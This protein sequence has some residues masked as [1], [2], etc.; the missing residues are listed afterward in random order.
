[1]VVVEE[2]EDDSVLTLTDQLF[3]LV[4]TFDRFLQLLEN[5]AIALDRQDFSDVKG[6]PHINESTNT[7]RS[8][9]QQFIDAY[10]FE[11]DYWPR[12]S[13]VRTKHISVQLV[14][15][16]IMGV[17]KGSE[18]SRES[19]IPLN[20]EDYLKRSS[21]LAPTFSSE[22]ERSRVYDIFEQYETMKHQRGDFDYVDR[23]VTLLKGMYRDQAL[24]QLLRSTFDEMYVDEVQDLR[25]LDIEL[26]F[27]I[28]RDGRG[29]H[30]AGD[31]AQAI[32]QDSTFRFADIKK[33]HYDHFALASSSTNQ[34][35]LGHAQLFA[36][37]ENHRSHQAILALASLV[38]GMI[39]EGFPETVDRLGPEIGNL[40]G[41]KPV[42]FIGCNFSIL[43]SSS[44]GSGNRPEKVA[45]FGAEQVILVR[46]EKMKTELRGLIGDVALIFT[47]LESKGMEFDDVILWDFFSGCPNQPGVRSLS[48]LK[49]EPAKF[50]SWKFSD[51]CT[52]LKRLYVA[53]TRARNQLF[54]VE[55]SVDTAATVFKLFNS[56]ASGALTDI[57][58]PGQKNFALLVDSMRPSASVDPASWA[59]RANDLMEQ[60]M[61]KDALMSFRKA[62]DQRGETRAQGH[63][64][65]EEGRRCLA[66]D[67]FEGS[68]TKFENA[69][70]QIREVKLVIDAVRVLERMGKFYRAAEL[71]LDYDKP[72][73]A[74]GLFLKAGSYSKAVDCFE[75]A[76]QYSE[77]AS[78][79]QDQGQYDRLVMYL[80]EHRAKLPIKDLKSYGFLCKLLLKQE[81]L[82][83]HA[84]QY[85]IELLG[86]SAEQ[87]ACFVQ[88]GMDKELVKLY[89]D[90]RR[91]GD[92]YHFYTKSGRLGS[93]TGVA[94]TDDLLHSTSEVSEFELLNLL[95]YVWAGHLVNRSSDLFTRDLRLES[96][97][98]NLTPK[99][100]QK[101]KQWETS[102]LLYGSNNPQAQV[103]FVKMDNT[104]VKRFLAFWIISNDEG[105]A[106]ISTLDALP[107]EMMQEAVRVSKDLV[108]KEDP[109][110]CSA[111]ALITGLWKTQHT[112][113]EDMF[114]P[115]SP[116]P[117][118][119][120]G[121]K[122]SDRPGVARQWVLDKIAAAV[123]ALHLRARDL[124][125]VKW[126]TRCV[127]FLTRGIPLILC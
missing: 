73:K 89:N 14:F 37:S 5:T 9:Q 115:W 65:E 106:R 119:M 114:L 78:I 58:R 70:A 123:Q 4:C 108:L 8:R 79:L 2:R 120:I 116:I 98:R 53:I 84:R 31:T 88:Y 32:S 64:S 33:M 12:F 56:D 93:A 68:T 36:L 45:D 25:C 28:V 49:N 74:V 11:V 59:K 46:D 87:E 54:I 122:S 20:R 66:N 67:D 40:T 113:G 109:G 3:P 94:L 29:F 112:Q 117:N 76:G 44:A 39:W 102:S 95:D 19:L 35:Q 42:L 103:D 1:M 6:F 41:P 99:M 77:A 80:I 127:R 83:Q 81:K 24:M 92:L 96:V 30:F 126:P 111:V 7:E 124:W 26:L 48:V 15:A 27:N 101:N 16:E 22:T 52:E 55:T 47:I 72:L 50:E 60:R 90:Q 125:D 62:G 23:V 85:A 57:T 21:R 13:H 107:F 10:A 86:S 17:I 71:W 118:R 97:T 104:P 61:F 34:N 69:Y 18:S 121:V 63:V 105:I 38:M 91:F 82:S 51:M 43:Q 100:V 75:V 110:A